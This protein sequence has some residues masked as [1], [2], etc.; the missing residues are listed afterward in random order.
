[1]GKA[2]QHLLINGNVKEPLDLAGVQVHGND[3]VAAS[4]LEHVGH[5]LGRNGRTRLVLAVLARIWK[6]GQHSRDAART[7]GLAGIDHD[8]QLQD[9]VVDIA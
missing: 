1:M 7:G 5:E 6:V 8:E 3:V 4:G 9:A 2:R